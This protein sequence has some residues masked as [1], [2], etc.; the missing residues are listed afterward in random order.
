MLNLA[1]PY[2][3]LEKKL[4]TDFVNPASSVDIRPEHPA[5]KDPRRKRKD[6]DKGMYNRYD[7]YTPL[8]TSSRRI[9]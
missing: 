4:N 2:I 6:T 1:Q 3:T 7:R 8:K 5:I 9:Y